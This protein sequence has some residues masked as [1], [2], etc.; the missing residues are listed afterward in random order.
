MKLVL[1]ALLVAACFAATPNQND[2]ACTNAEEGYTIIYYG[3]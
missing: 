3:E 1:L 2:R